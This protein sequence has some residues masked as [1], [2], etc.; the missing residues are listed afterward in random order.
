[1]THCWTASPSGSNS[2]RKRRRRRW[3]AKMRSEQKQDGLSAI[4]DSLRTGRPLGSPVWVEGVA[5]RLGIDP[6]PRPRGLTRKDR[7]QAGHRQGRT[8]IA[9]LTELF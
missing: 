4:R 7:G 8:C 6:T 9:F 2:A 5:A 3:R 1:L